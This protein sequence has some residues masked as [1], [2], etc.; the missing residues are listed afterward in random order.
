MMGAVVWSVHAAWRC[1]L[2][3]EG[4]TCHFCSHLVAQSKA[5]PCLTP[6]GHGVFISIS[7]VYHRDWGLLPCLIFIFASKEHLK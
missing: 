7:N 6:R 4:D 2:P 3:P 5:Q 1:P